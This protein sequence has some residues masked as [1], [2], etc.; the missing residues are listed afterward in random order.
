MKRKKKG[1]RRKKIA[2]ATTTKTTTTTKRQKCLK[3]LMRDL[4]ATL[5]QMA[6]MQFI[7][8]L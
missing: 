3:K 7:F 1:K 8:H 6:N 4:F 5:L 2:T